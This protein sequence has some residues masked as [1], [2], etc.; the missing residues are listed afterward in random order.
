MNQRDSSI[1]S[2]QLTHRFFLSKILIL[3]N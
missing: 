1:Q 3:T 2:S